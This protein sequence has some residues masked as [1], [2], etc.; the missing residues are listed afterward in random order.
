MKK[1]IA[2]LGT[3]GS[4]GAAFTRRTKAAFALT[5]ANTGNLAFQYGVFHRVLGDARVTVPFTFDPALVRDRCRLLCIPA[6]NFLYSGFD[7]GDLARRLEETGLPLMVL[8]LG[9]QAFRDIDEV[10]LK[11]GTERL[12]HLFRER[13]RRIMLRGRH[14]AAVLERHGVQNFEVLGCPS[15]FIN[16]DPALGAS[17]A[18][19]LAERPVASIAFAPTFYPFNAAIERALLD[20]IGMDRL[21]EIVAQDPLAAIAVARGETDASETRAWLEGRAGFLTNAAPAEREELCRRIRAYFS[22][23][24]WLEAYQRVDGVIGTR[25]H[26]A[27]LGWQAGRAALVVSYD[28]RTEE[29]AETM[30]LP[31]VKAAALKPGAALALM[32]ERVAVLAPEYDARRRDLA[33]R[34]VAL[35]GEHDVTPGTVLA[36]LAT[37]AAATPPGDEASAGPAEPPAGPRHWGFLEQYNRRRIAGWV[38]SSDAVPPGVTI[39]FDGID[40]G[41]VLP[42]KARPDIG[43]NAWAFELRPPPEAVTKDVVRVEAVFTGSGRPLRNSP[44]VTSIAADDAAKVLRGSEGYL[45][46]RNDSNRVI[47]QVTGKRI[48]S[49]AELAQWEAFLRGLDE[50]AQSRG[51]RVVYLVAPNKECVFAEFLPDDVVVAETRPVRQLQALAAR[52]DLRATRMVYPLEALR[53]AGPQFATYPKGDSHW[54]DYGATVALE[55]LYEALGLPLATGAKFHSEFRNADLLSKLGGVCVEQQPV[56]DRRPV[57]VAVHDNGVL[58]T[59]RRRDLR[60]G[61]GVDA[62]AQRLLIMHDSFGEWLI[63]ALAERFARTTAIWNASLDPALLDDVRPDVIILERAERFLVVPPRF[64]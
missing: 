56:L 37:G 2:I 16:P 6:A 47:D 50:A 40:I 55:A 43:A 7:L 32:A 60:A 12:L 25:I 18:A 24:A 13:C 9:A 51:A 59:G 1:P 35:L 23:E 38:A 52:L 64:G 54:S 57:A 39:R 49:D 15:N 36:Q 19:R 22:A 20:E 27:A 28:L 46:L 4:I 53:R 14:T 26:G 61:H 63:P 3:E 45:F 30:G 41:A 21:A 42:T 5:G 8:G 17:I 31:L 11:P 48:L 33:A 34:L 29:L 62:E 58:N 44:V 10:K